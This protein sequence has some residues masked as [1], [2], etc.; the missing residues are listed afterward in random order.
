MLRVA[1]AVTACI[2]ACYSSNPA[3]G[4]RCDDGT[5][6]PAGL[7]C[8]PASSTC[9]RSAVDARVV[10]SPADVSIDA[11]LCFGDGFTQYCFSATPIG[12]LTIA[13]D[14][15]FSTTVGATGSLCSSEF[16]DVCVIAAVDIS[17]NA[18]VSATGKRSLAV[19]AAHSISIGVDGVIDVASHGPTLVLGTA[20]LGA[21]ADTTGCGMGTPPPGIGGG[22]GGSAIGIGGDGG[23][24]SD[25][26]AGGVP[27]PAFQITSLHGGCA[28][29]AS[30][31]SLVQAGLGGG[32]VSLVAGTSI[33]VAGYINAS[34]SQGLGAPN[35]TASGGTGGGSGGM[36]VLDAP[37]VMIEVG[38]IVMANGGGG[39]EGGDGTSAGVAGSDPSTGAP[40]NPASGGGGGSTFG[41]DGGA[42][43]AGATKNGSKGA[44]G[45]PG[46]GAGGGGGGGGAGLIGIH[47]TVVRNGGVTTPGTTSI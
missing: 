19:V 13:S 35:G 37:T 3:T 7:V 26:T 47:G 23:V 1:V 27:A 14:T 4:S 17:I 11:R 2:A 6:C 12:T 34:G 5:Q 16:A 25:G 9:E 20:T 33:D 45:T 44:A 46:D 38:S 40:L 15:A 39:G 18:V 43:S 29:D 31:G 42:G 8:S 32:G 36:I 30:H 10:D 28:G 41:G 21:G 22:H 24:A